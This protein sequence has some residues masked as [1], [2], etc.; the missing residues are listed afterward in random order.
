MVQS[1]VDSSMHAHRETIEI[2]SILLDI[3][4]LSEADAIFMVY[5]WETTA[6]V[7]RC[8]PRAHSNIGGHVVQIITSKNSVQL[9]EMRLVQR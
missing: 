8:M 4:S 1:F 5:A 7:C 3:V 9:L 6:F 2:M